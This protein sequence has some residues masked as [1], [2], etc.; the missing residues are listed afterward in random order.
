M[1]KRSIRTLLATAALLLA[2]QGAVAYTLTAGTYY[3]DNTS[4]N[5]SKV[6]M[7]IGTTSWVNVY[8]MSKV[9]GNA[10]IWSV[11]FSSNQDNYA[12]VQFAS[13]D[14]YNYTSDCGGD[15]GIYNGNVIGSG[16]KTDYVTEDLSPSFPLF[17]AT[18]TI[19]NGYV[20][21]NQQSTG[22]RGQSCPSGVSQSVSLGGTTITA[23]STVG[24][25]LPGAT[26]TL[27]GSTSLTY[28]TANSYDKVHATLNYYLQGSSY[29]QLSASGNNSTTKTCSKSVTLPTATGE[30]NTS[31]YFKCV[32]VASATVTAKYHIVGLTGQSLNFGSVSTSSNK[33]LSEALTNVWDGDGTAS[34]TATITGTN[35]SDFTFANGTQSTTI[36]VTSK[37]GSENITFTP[38]TTGERTATLTLTLSYNSTSKDYT[39]TLSGK[40]ADG[41]IVPKIAS[42]AVVLAGPSAT[43]H[44]Y[45]QSANCKSMTERGFYIKASS[46]F[47][48]DNLACTTKVTDANTDEITTGSSW[49]ATTGTLSANTTY[50]YRSYVTDDESDTEIVSD[51]IRTFHTGDACNYALGDTIY[52]TIDKS[53]GADDACALKYRGF[54]NA[55]AKIKSST[56]STSN[57]LNY[58]IVFLVA[59]AAT[60]Y[61]G[62]STTSK[63]GGDA[64]DLSTILFE[65]INSGSSPS[66]V[67]VIRSSVPTKR[68]VIQHPTLR[69][70][71]NIIFDN[72]KIVGS[73]V[74]GATSG[75]Y[76]N[77]MDIDNDKTIWD[78]LTDSDILTNANITIKN[79]YIWSE[80]FT[81][82]HVASYDGITLENN[83]IEAHLES[84]SLNDGNVICWGSSVKFLQ[85]KNIKFIRNNFRGSHATSFWVQGIKGLLMMNNVF[86]NSNDSFNSD[87]ADNTC[88]VRLVT[89]FTANENQKIGIYYN[90]FYIDEYTTTTPRHVD[91]FRLGRYYK[92]N[93][94]LISN[95]SQNQYSTIR[96]M[97][98]NCYNYDNT[99]IGANV[100][101]D[102]KWC[103]T[104]TEGNWCSSINYNNYW[105]RYDEARH[106]EESVFNIPSST[107]CTSNT[108]YYVNV[109]NL[110]CSNTSDPSLLVIKGGDL[111]LGT[112]L[113]SNITGLGETNYYNDRL[114]PS[115]ENDAVRRTNGKWTLGAYQQTEGG[116][117]LGDMVWWGDVSADWDDRANWRKPD[118]SRVTCVDNISTDVRMIIPAPHSTQYK[119]PDGG[120]TRYPEMPSK[121]E[122]TRT[123]LT[124]EAVNAG[125]GYSIPTK[126]AGNIEIEYGGALKNVS[127]LKDD[128]GRRYTEATNYFTAGRDEWILVGT[129]IKPFDNESK[130]SV[131]LVQSGDYFLYHWPHVYMHKAY[132][133]EKSGDTYPVNWQVPFA[134]LDE[135]VDY[136]TVFA[137]QIP[138]QYGPN[139]LP[140]QWVGASGDE[141]EKKT[142]TFNGW[143]LNDEIV[144]E[145]KISG[146]VLLCNTYP[147]NIDVATAQTE[148]SGSIKYYDYSTGVRN[149]VSY[150]SGT[151]E[152]KSGNGFLFVPNGSNDGWF[153]ISNTMLTETSTIYK[154]APSVNPYFIVNAYN[155]SGAGGS[156]A[157]IVNDVLKSDA[158]NAE[159]DLINT[160]IDNTPAQP[161]VYVMMYNRELDKVVVPDIS[162]SIPLGLVCGRKMTVVFGKYEAEGIVKAVLVDTQ[163]DKQYDITEGTASITL[164][165]GTYT[166]RFYLNL[167][168]D[169]E[170]VT[171]IE[172]T[173]GSNEPES[174]TNSVSISAYGSNVIITSTEG[175]VLQEA[176]ITDMTGHTFVVKLNNDHL[177]K[178]HLNVA[179]GVYVIKAIGDNAS[180]TEKVIIK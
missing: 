59:P 111:N 173:E 125:H 38:S 168:L 13:T 17:I 180:R 136:N 39:Y 9:N 51:D 153:R 79:S 110:V 94:Q 61:T 36:S 70:S 41:S 22:T 63:T 151:K 143:L 16:Y 57:N 154:S 128:G 171:S 11:T 167:S 64:T 3:F 157:A 129:V 147:A 74:A 97:Y 179:S 155:A 137:I 160:V 42:D 75:K 34:V 133:G 37:S 27:S 60:N 100:D 52:F 139:K 176:Y 82:I 33:T 124:S 141:T 103:L 30:Y 116:A 58:N 152:I 6:Y 24:Y 28:G 135:K 164:A 156:T 87:Y 19:S 132:V 115:N 46:S 105:S 29:S 161:E 106:S 68:P 85:S 40:G 104:D 117:P 71:R 165:K 32:G 72:V 90:T 113:A 109:E 43:M 172:E 107:V 174:V 65:D 35:A 18:S 25:F 21:L 76:D 88:F 130:S 96:F 8:E 7:R 178:I 91:Y 1:I 102:N 15:C 114:H 81:C 89:Q 53:L 56:F 4:T 20:V 108:Q 67:L 120:I 148:N 121:F 119:I 14:G 78:E 138:N 48:K 50:Y 145:Y 134:D 55:I 12:A 95:L 98:N 177:N 86:W 77:A 62:G 149:F 158:F 23:G 2:A 49:S 127:S 80:G 126:F 93:T 5:W 118:G 123:K 142:F 140:A 73:S 47:A 26:V 170:T 112:A 166:G 175:V 131:R 31:H 122:G 83:D 69:S 150:V 146:P 159:T 84:T 44:G 92:Y 54:D 66:K 45:L 163:E 162:Q 101:G 10:N 169:D 144:P 99:V